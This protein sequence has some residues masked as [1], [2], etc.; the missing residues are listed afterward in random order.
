[1]LFQLM[2]FQMLLQMFCTHV[3]QGF[4]G[5]L[6]FQTDEVAHDQSLEMFDF[7]LLT[8]LPW[9]E[10]VGVEVAVSVDNMV[11]GTAD[12]INGFLDAFLCDHESPVDHMFDVCKASPQQ[13]A[14]K[15]ATAERQA[16]SQ[17]PAAACSSRIASVSRAV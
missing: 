12:Q 1:M 6:I 2:S 14:T 13:R 7:M 15:R 10:V 11:G 4:V 16:Q 3:D 17:A 9:Q 8:E 5:L